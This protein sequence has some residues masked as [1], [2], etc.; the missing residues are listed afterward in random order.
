M[1]RILILTALFFSLALPA[2]AMAGPGVIDRVS[3][4]PSGGNGPTHVDQGRISA[5]G[6]CVV[7]DTTEALT[8][9]DVNTR[10]DIYERCDGVTKLVSIGPVP[11]AGS[12]AASYLEFRGMSSDGSC[13]VF[14]TNAA[15]TDDDGD[16]S[17]DIYKRCGSNVER[18]SQGPNGGNVAQDVHHGEISADGVCVMFQ[19]HE[20]LTS[21]D[22]DSIPDIYER[23]GSTTKRIS[24][25]PA[26]GD[27][28]QGYPQP[29]SLTAD[30]SCVAFDT[31]EK[32]TADDGDDQ[33]DVYVRCGSEIKKLTP[34]DGAFDTSFDRLSPDGKC[35]VF[36][37]QEQL[38][39]TDTDTQN[40]LYRSC[41]GSAQHLS[42]GPAGGG[43]DFYASGTDVSRDA[44]CVL[45]DTSERITA[46][47]TDS[48]NDVYKRCGSTVERV[49]T[50]DGG[51]NAEIDAEGDWISPDGRCALFTTAEHITSDDTDATTDVFERC[52]DTTERVAQGPTGGNGAFVPQAYAISYD[53]T[54]VVFTTDE[55]LTADDTNDVTDIYE[56]SGGQTTRVSPDQ[57]SAN[58]YGSN[59]Q[60][61]SD[62]ASRILFARFD[63][64]TSD[65]S[66]DFF[67]L[68]L[69]TIAPTAATGGASDIGQTGA[70]VSGTSSAI[71][72]AKYHFEYG[73]QAGVYGS[74]TPEADVPAGGSVSAALSGLA[75][76]TTHHYRLVVVS[77]GGTTHGLDRSFTTGATT[78]PPGG[79]GGNDGGTSDGGNN[80][81]DTPPPAP[82][83]GVSIA[84]GTVKVKGRVAKVR[85]TCPAAAQGACRGTLTLTLAY[86]SA[87]VGA[88]SFKIAPGKSATVAVRITKAGGKLLAR[89]RVLKAT[90]SAVAR[91]GRG[92]AVTRTA[93]LT[94]GRG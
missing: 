70:T 44:T 66:D 43:G 50:G 3:Q 40:D 7:F 17:I 22:H 85:L 31:R 34:G 1:P 54:R 55:R 79:N 15:L 21:D 28:P 93:K 67:D 35:V 33:I 86:K 10:K 26:G 90:A 87:K 65:D 16:S 12:A 23:C 8:S 92:T 77:A 2:A 20:A 78:P 75:P 25:G 59:P 60:G 52:G 72:A 46:D 83:A 9:D 6:R 38:A 62:D 29:E 76:G 39:S 32:L 30:G 71:P 68:Y 36:E 94:L 19:V 82:F 11:G 45:F 84:P 49:S 27:D 14:D 57:A 63:R 69:A 24:Y 88:K 73:T 74:S 61:A 41:G 51:G 91:D 89:K 13:V 4:G 53:G 18:V 80:G 5:D 37:T 81:G 58:P 56:R 48:S 42:T 47:D 64:L